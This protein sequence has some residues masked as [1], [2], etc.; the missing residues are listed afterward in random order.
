MEKLKDIY[1]DNLRMYNE[2]GLKPWLD[3][4]LLILLLEEKDYFEPLKL[5]VIDFYKFYYRVI[6]EKIMKIKKDFNLTE[7]NIIEQKKLKGFSDDED[8]F[9]FIEEVI[10]I[11][12]SYIKDTSKVTPLEVY[13]QYFDLFEKVD[14]VERERRQPKVLA[15]YRKVNGVFRWIP[16]E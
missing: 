14:G 4:M 16:I 15:K 3:E 11:I 13:Y 7:E 9:F 12:H 6:N 1:I 5:T 2:T 10:G 8:I